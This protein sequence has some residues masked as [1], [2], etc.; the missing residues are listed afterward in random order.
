MLRAAGRI[1][2]LSPKETLI[3]ELLTE[4]DEMY[5]LELVAASKRGLKRGTIYVTLARME[6]KGYVTSRLEDPPADEG[7]LPRRLYKP[8]AHGR[9]VLETWTRVAR[10]LMPEFAK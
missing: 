6:D 5:G 1:P 3:L 10:Q 7:G 4:G 9:R 8:T 2:T